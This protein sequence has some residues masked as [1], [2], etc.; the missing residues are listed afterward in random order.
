VID[1]NLF[2]SASISPRGVPSRLLTLW[3]QN[4]IRVITS[5]ELVAEVEG[6]L[7]RDSIKGKYQL[8]EERISE[9]VTRLQQ[10]AEHVSPL[11]PLPLHSRDPKD[12]KLLAVALGGEADYLITGDA[13]LL[14][15]RAE[16]ALR[17][18]TIMTAAAFL[19]TEV[20]GEG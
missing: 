6:V 11:T 3:E 13:D 4:R 12:D 17:N 5:S 15:L 16:P 2:V 20:S 1:T 8:A 19:E 10:A 9:L 14:S 18:L 7:H